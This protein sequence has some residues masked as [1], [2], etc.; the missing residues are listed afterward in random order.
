MVTF[1]PGQTTVTLSIHIVDD[2]VQECPGLESFTL[3]LEV[4]QA[5]INLCVVKELPDTARVNIQDDDG[6]YFST[7]FE[8]L[9]VSIHCLVISLSFLFPASRC[10]NYVRPSSQTCS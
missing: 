6:T 7:N 5:S 2:D 9:T 3:A 8:G 4:P 1:M 10:E